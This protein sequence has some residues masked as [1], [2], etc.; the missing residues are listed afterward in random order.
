MVPELVPESQNHD[1]RTNLV[2]M[3][4]KLIKRFN[5]DVVSDSSAESTD[6]SSTEDFPRVYHGRVSE[7]ARPGAVVEFEPN[8]PIL[9]RDK[10]QFKGGKATA[11]PSPRTC[12]AVFEA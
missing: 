4:F 5:M 10:S 8:N 6:S 3:E 1:D 11:S 9:A 2:P 12:C 7:D